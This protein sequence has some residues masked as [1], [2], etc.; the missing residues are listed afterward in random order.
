M[1]I[2]T[3]G[4]NLKFSLKTMTKGVWRDFLIYYRY[5]LQIIGKALN[6]VIMIAVAFLMATFFNLNPSASQLSGI[7]A[8]QD[9]LFFASG[10]VLST[11]T[12]V[13]LWGP[14]T[15]IENDL[16]FG[17]IETIFVSPVSRF[18]YLI[19]P[20]ISRAII[21]SIFFL[22]PYLLVL[23]LSG[24]LTNGYVIGFTLLITFLTIISLMAFG[25]FFALFAILVRQ[26]RAVALILSTIFQ[27]LC[28]SLI[29]VQSYPSFHFVIGSILKYSAM[30]FPYT[31][32]YD[33]MR[34]YIIGSNYRPLL[35]IWS[36]Y[37][38]LFVTSIIFLLIAA[39]CLRLVEQKAK[40]GGLAIL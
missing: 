24:Y 15:Q 16:Y 10:V 1:S 28:G 37:V 13:A 38:L 8:Q 11:Y 29:P 32:C 36:E 26:A 14:L 17:T 34:Y 22:P 6:V 39:F 3:F 25:L 27:Y 40:K 33:L 7:T 12:G 4:S 20:T 2:Q 18:A 23:G 30:V 35:P 19:S 21:N 9:F 31:Y 5:P